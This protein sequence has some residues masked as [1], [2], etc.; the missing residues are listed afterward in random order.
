[1]GRE[2]SVCETAIDVKDVKERKSVS[3]VQKR[4]NTLMFSQKRTRGTKESVQGD[5]FEYN[6]AKKLMGAECR[7]LNPLKRL[8]RK[9]SCLMASLS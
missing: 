4:S 5:V 1:M 9:L 8:K 3:D 6:G 7:K 2:E